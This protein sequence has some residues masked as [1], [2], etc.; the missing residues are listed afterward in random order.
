MSEFYYRVKDDSMTGDRIFCGDE[1]LVRV[2][3]TVTKNDICAIMSEVDISQLEFRR[4]EN[5][6]GGYLLI[7]SNPEV[8]RETRDKIHIVGKIIMAYKNT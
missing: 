4:I 8:R 3:E 7:P 5:Q 2:T 6:S 1:V